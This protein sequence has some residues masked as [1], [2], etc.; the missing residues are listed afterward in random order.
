MHKLL[1]FFLLISLVAFTGCR[2]NTDTLRGLADWQL[3]SEFPAQNVI[4]NVLVDNNMYVIQEKKLSLWRPDGSVKEMPHDLSGDNLVVACADYFVKVGLITNT[5]LEFFPLRNPGYPNVKSFKFSGADFGL[6]GNVFLTGFRGV[7]ALNNQNKFLLAPYFNDGSGSALLLFEVNMSNTG[8][9]IDSVRFKR[10]NIPAYQSVRYTYPVGD[11]FLVST[12]SNNKNTAYWVDSNGNVQEFSKEVFTQMV[13]V[14]GIYYA[15]TFDN[16]LYKSEDEGVTWTRIA[17]NAS[18]FSRLFS[19]IGST[20]KRT[21]IQNK[22]VNF[23]TYDILLAAHNSNGILE[24]TR[25]DREGVNDE[26]I[27]NLNEWRGQVY[28][29]TPN[30]IFTRSI[31]DFFTPAFY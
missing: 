9:D 18:S 1:L 24:S 12:V 15:N 29:F 27:L 4:D 3:T 25:L 31:S 8:L 14:E 10:L 2:K 17:P 5:H 6:G 28:A 16:G 21:L 7:Y 19:Y 22:E 26:P 13:Q 30:G 23:L 20:P 11:G